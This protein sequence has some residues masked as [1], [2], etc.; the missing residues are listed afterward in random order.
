MILSVTNM[1]VCMMHYTK[2]IYWNINDY[3]APL[4]F[5]KQT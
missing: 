4:F 2:S 3:L 1:M 5:S